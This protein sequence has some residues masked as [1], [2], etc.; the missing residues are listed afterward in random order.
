MNCGER[1]IC[2]LPTKQSQHFPED[3]Y[4][5][6]C[7]LVSNKINEFREV[8]IST[9]EITT[10]SQK[11]N[12]ISD[13]IMNCVEYPKEIFII[14]EIFLGCK[15]L[16]LSNNLNIIQN[17]IRFLSLAIY[18][19]SNLSESLSDLYPLIFNIRETKS[20]ILIKRY[21]SLITNIFSDLKENHNYTLIDQLIT[22]YFADLFNYISNLISITIYEETLIFLNALSSLITSEKYCEYYLQLTSFLIT[23]L[24]DQRIQYSENFQSIILWSLTE[25]C[26]HNKSE[27]SNITLSLNF[28]PFLVES[29]DTFPSC[30]IEPVLSILYFCVDFLKSADFISSKN[31]PILVHFSTSSNI[32]IQF[33]SLRLLRVLIQFYPSEFLSLNLNEVINFFNQVQ[34]RSSKEIFMIACSLVFYMPDSI[35]M[36]ENSIIQQLIEFIIQ[37]INFDEESSKSALLSL[38][39]IK[40]KFVKFGKLKSF[41]NILN[42]FESIEELTENQSDE[43]LDLIDKV[44]ST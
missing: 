39:K 30:C 9:K 7:K 12:E 13:V 28:L 16:L 3:E 25:N 17:T 5:M 35:V 15:T 31:L 23:L 21:F 18:S 44:T 26:K 43:V 24:N 42:Q 4:I 34:F 29:I 2:F 10:I 32:H 33:D 8:M 14:P 27:F 41:Q 1:I 22:T 40:E 6:I 19:T 11:L 20:E 37:N 38:L 36:A